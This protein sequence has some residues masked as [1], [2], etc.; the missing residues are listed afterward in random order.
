MRSFTSRKG[1]VEAEGMVELLHAV[2]QA[3]LL[4]EEFVK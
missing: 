2:R 4:G 1:L 3:H